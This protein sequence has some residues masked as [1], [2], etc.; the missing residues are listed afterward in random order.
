MVLGHSF[1]PA[2]ARPSGIPSLPPQACSLAPP[3][4][5]SDIML[6]QMNTP[7]PSAVGRM[8]Y[9]FVSWS[10]RLREIAGFSLKSSQPRDGIL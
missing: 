1:A 8:L 3:A 6:A 7:K 10:I 5:R 9:V 2:S 4:R